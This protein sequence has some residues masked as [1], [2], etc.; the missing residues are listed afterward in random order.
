MRIRARNSE[1]RATGTR[2]SRRT[3]FLAAAATPLLSRCSSDSNSDTSA[4]TRLL[5]RSVDEISRGPS[6]T[7]DEV[8]STPF[9]SLGMRVGSGA[10]NMLILASRAAQSTV[11]TS[12][13]HIAL[14]IQYGRVIR[15]AG[16]PHNLSGTT[17]PRSDPLANG[18]QGLGAAVSATRSA[19]F[20]DRNAFGNEIDSTIAVT[21][22]AEIEIL[23]SRLKTIHAVERCT[24]P[25]LSWAFTN[26]FWIGSLDGR[27]WRS[28]QFVH[29]EL[30]ALEIELFRPPKV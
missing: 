18:V 11:W 5:V 7:L 24:C 28:V 19:D 3:I 15:T 26:E 14:E 27:M 29:P 6:I 25:K 20:T 12:A 22:P 21:G 10:Q 2:V 9:A 23:G 30:D 8:A 16:L 1:T 13:S 4:L 17:F